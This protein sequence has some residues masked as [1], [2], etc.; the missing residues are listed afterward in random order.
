MTAIWKAL[1]TAWRE[2]WRE[3]KRQRHGRRAADPFQL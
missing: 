1:R 2:G 3:F